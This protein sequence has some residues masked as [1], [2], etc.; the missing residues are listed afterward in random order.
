MTKKGMLVIGVLIF[1]LAALAQFTFNLIGVGAEDMRMVDTGHGVSYAFDANPSFYSNNSRFFYFAT[2]TGIRYVPSGS[3]SGGWQETFSLTRP[4]IAA[5][6]DIVAVGEIERGRIV[7]VYNS[8]GYMYSVALDHPL[9]GFSVNATGYLSVITQVDGGYYIH[10]YNQQHNVDY[11]MQR[12]SYHVDFPMHFPV[13]AEISE[14]GQYLAIAYL[15]LSGRNLAT[16]L[17]FLH[18]GT[19]EA[20]FGTD[21]LFAG[22]DLDEAFVAMRFMANNQLLL[23]T[24][25]QIRLLSIQDNTFQE[26]WAGP[27]NNRIDQLAFCGNNRFAFASGA[28]ISPD[29]RDADPLG[30]VNIFDL[31]GQ[32]GRFYL[33]RRATHL[34]MGH[35]AV[36]VGSDRYFHAVSARGTG[37]WHHFALH[38]VRDMIFLDNTDTV[39]IA[40]AN[41]AYVWRRQRIRD[42]QDNDVEE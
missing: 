10:V 13:S 26:V 5:R 41:R 39:L 29:G 24:D 25:T 2:R 14:D 38:D 23:I 11:V 40:G 6:G 36:I 30:T 17:E 18:I 19:Q 3:G 12:R 15:N 8:S 33:G 27:L 31:N 42:G 37:L 9:M 32:T 16:E 35:G 28:P 21:S 34:S 20:R 22:K 7:Y 4:H 1:G